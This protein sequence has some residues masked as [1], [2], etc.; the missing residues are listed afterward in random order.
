MHVF[1]L[2]SIHSAFTRSADNT[3]HMFD[4]R[5]LSSGGVGSPVH[6]FVGHSAAV[7][8][9]QWSPDKSSVFGSSAED[10]ILNIWDHERIAKKQ[11]TAGLKAPNAPPGLFFQHAGHR[12]KVVDF[13][14]NTSDP[15]TIVSVSD[16]CES[17]NGGG[18]LQDLITSFVLS[19]RHLEHACI[20]S[21][22]EVIQTLPRLCTKC[23]RSESVVIKLHKMIWR[24]IDLIYRPVDEVLSELDKFKS[25]ILA[26][27]KN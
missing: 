2:P 5:N 6:K 26:C 8:C 20:M 1:W 24:M 22:R 10:G 15:W 4:R 16:D 25:H 9:V 17:T 23:C 13:H 27:E 18:T 3:I 12:D 7:L 21:N 19:W 11:E 14:W